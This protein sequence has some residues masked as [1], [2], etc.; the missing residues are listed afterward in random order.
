MLLSG[1]HNMKNNLKYWKKFY[2]KAEVLPHSPF[3]EWALTH[4]NGSFVELG[5]GN[6]RDLNYFLA[7]GLKGIGVD[8]AY[9][10]DNIAKMDIVAYMKR[11]KS[12]DNVYTRF[13]W[14]AI[15][16]PLQL[17]I[18]Q[19]ASGNLFIEARTTLDMDRKK[20]FGQHAR[21]YIDPEQIQLDLDEY[22]FEM[23]DGEMGTGLSKY[24]GEDP[25]L[26]R[27][28]AKKKV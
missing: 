28:F 3:A 19:W 18:L 25:H 1:A 15:D 13:F 23:V 21:N 5:C 6:G 26:I 16:R 2:R 7:K 10:D 24:K 8:S 12:P 9:E 20:V 4:M 17:K 14:H 22:G 11:N 27:I